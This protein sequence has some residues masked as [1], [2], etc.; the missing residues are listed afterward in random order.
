MCDS[1]NVVGDPV[2][3]SD[4]GTDHGNGRTGLGQKRMGPGGFGL[5]GLDHQ[6]A[7]IDQ[8]GATDGVADLGEDLGLLLVDVV[9]DAGHQHCHLGVDAFVL[10]IE[11]STTSRCW[12]VPSNGVDHRQW[13]Q[14]PQSAP[15][16]QVVAAD[17][18]T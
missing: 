2:D 1:A 3:G 9:A 8:V 4:D 16:A 17:V 7:E 10:G 12:V 14:R 15:R 13:S 5:L 6:L 18:D 11:D